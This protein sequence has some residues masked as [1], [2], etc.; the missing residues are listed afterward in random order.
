MPPP[1]LTPAQAAALQLR[2]RADTWSN[3][4]TGLGVDGRDKRLGADFD[5]AVLGLNDCEALYRA[6]DMAARAADLPRREMTREWC[7]VQVE[8]AGDASEQLPAEHE[9]LGSKD[10]F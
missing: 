4:I 9:R 6:D 1:T 2:V 7:E 10:K 3:V 5:V 8:G